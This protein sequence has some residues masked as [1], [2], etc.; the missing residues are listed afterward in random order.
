MIGDLRRCP[1]RIRTLTG[2]TKKSE[3][4]PL[5]HRAI[6]ECKGANLFHILYTFAELFY[7]N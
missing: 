2:G 7:R 5:H 4:L 6:F 3:V 1:G